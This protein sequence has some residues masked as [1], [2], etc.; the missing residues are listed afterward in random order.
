[1]AIFVS[2]HLH[3]LV[4]ILHRQQM[5]E[6]QCD[7]PLVV[8]NHPDGAS[9]ARFY[10]VEFRHIPV[11][12]ETKSQVEDEQ[13]RLLVEYGIELTILARYMQILSPAVRAEASRCA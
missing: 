12:P 9:H 4:D 10:G 13:Q 7:I 8:G 1:M 2:Q 5:G 11:T 3:C 6:L